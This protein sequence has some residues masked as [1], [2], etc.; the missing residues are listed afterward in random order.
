MI[1]D[2]HNLVFIIILILLQIFAIFS[3]CVK[4]FFVLGRLFFLTDYNSNFVLIVY[5]KKTLIPFYLKFK[6]S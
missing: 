5:V 3:I 6:I 1:C 2:L 4:L